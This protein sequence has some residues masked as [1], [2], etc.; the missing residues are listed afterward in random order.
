MSLRGVAASNLRTWKPSKAEKDDFHK[1]REGFLMKKG[2]HPSDIYLQVKS[3]IQFIAMIVA[4][5]HTALRVVREWLLTF[6]FTM[7]AMSAKFEVILCSRHYLP[8]GTNEYP[9][10][11][12]GKRL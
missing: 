9:S 6:S 4:P 11:K 3:N 10:M 5:R 8:R 7:C 2:A 12:C 1:I